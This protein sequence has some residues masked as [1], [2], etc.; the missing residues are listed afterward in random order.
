[1]HAL[2]R[3]THLELELK[4]RMTDEAL[5]I[6]AGAE[7]PSVLNVNISR[8]VSD[9]AI[10]G[11]IRQ[12]RALRRLVIAGKTQSPL[13]DAAFARAAE[14][15]TLQA[16]NV[17][18]VRGLTVQTL[19][20][21]IAVPRLTDL[22]VGDSV[23]LNDAALAHLEHSACQATLSKLNISSCESFT[24]AGLALLSRMPALRSLNVSD[25][26]QRT[27]TDAGF[28]ALAQSGSL[29]ELAMQSCCPRHDHECCARRAG[30]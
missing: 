23:W 17:V 12:S 18:G 29:Q 7:R 24:D 19:L 22:N 15:A 27:L 28:V 1:V 6:V 3:L 10:D 16:V 14:C 5:F 20:S 9:A 30:A 8:S 13:S 2:A 11:L 4:Y 21:V 25:C 26:Q